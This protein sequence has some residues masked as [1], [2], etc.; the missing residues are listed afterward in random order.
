MPMLEPKTIGVVVGPQKT[1]AL[2]VV[3]QLHAWCE[4]HS[5]ALRAAAPVAEQV[6]CPP[7]SVRDDELDEQVDLIVV[8]G[9]DGTMLGAARLVGTRRIPVLGVN[10]GSLGYLTEFTLAELFTALDGWR[11]GHFDVDHRMVIEVSRIRGGQT[12]E[13]QRALNDAVIN[14]SARARMIEFDCYVNEHFVNSFRADGMIVA[15][16]TGSTAYSLSAGGPIVHP[17]MSAILLTP[18]CPHT[19]SNRPVVLPDDV[20]VDLALKQTGDGAVLT[21]DGQRTV[22]LTPDDR[23]LVRRSPTTFDLVRPTNRNYFEVL[24]TKLKWGTR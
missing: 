19:L 20:V 4:E 5:I 8:L 13:T 6:A 16:P 2:A 12:L 11:A 3:R 22:S 10:F 23:I 1:D 17:S 24:R 9:G 7:L 21:I 14:Q 15:T 18:I